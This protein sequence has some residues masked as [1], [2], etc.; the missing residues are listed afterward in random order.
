MLLGELSNKTTQDIYLSISTRGIMSTPGKNVSTRDLGG[1]S[2]QGL[3]QTL[4]GIVNDSPKTLK[5][6]PDLDLNTSLNR[7]SR[8]HALRVYKDGH[9]KL[10]PSH[11]RGEGGNSSLPTC[12]LIELPC[13]RRWQVPVRRVYSTGDR[14]WQVQ[15][16]H[17]V[18]FSPRQ[19]QVPLTG[20]FIDTRIQKSKI[21]QVMYDMRQN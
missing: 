10:C 6:I 15:K 18:T 5:R 17:S 7:G 9:E 19:D 12:Q 8:A 14:A 2:T 20:I 4:Q 1:L 11:I 21:K 3:F 16:V 13:W